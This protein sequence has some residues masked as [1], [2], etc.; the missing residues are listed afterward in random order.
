MSQHKRSA[1]ETA[2]HRIRNL[3][4]Y[5]EVD[6]T[7]PLSERGLAEK[8]GL[9]RTPVREALKELAN[10]GFLD[11]IPTYGTFVRKLTLDDLREIFEVRQGLEGVA[12]YLAAVRGPSGVFDDCKD[13]LLRLR[14]EK[15]P[16]VIA[17]QRVGWAVHDAIFLAAGNGRLEESYKKLHAQSGVALLQIRHYDPARA[18]SAI[19][20]HL[21]II[22]AIEGRDPEDAQRKMWS[23]LASA[24]RARFGML[25]SLGSITATERADNG[26][27]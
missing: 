1:R 2:Y 16:D 25:T 15:E 7:E 9:G 19:E 17:S 11:I 14:G 12:C 26:E 13:S 4:A 21:G 6:P 10:D 18:K 27:A 8:L 23:H 5:G 3:I 24:F 20:Q 22:E